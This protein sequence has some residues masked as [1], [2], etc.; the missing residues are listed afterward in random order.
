[1]KE[2]TFDQMTE[3]EGYGFW[4]GFCDGVAAASSI[5]AIYGGYAFYAG[6]ALGPGAVVAAAA[7]G[8]AGLGCVAY[9]VAT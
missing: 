8:V 5:A 4:S 6:I 1:M 7:L 9:S 2:L 3:I